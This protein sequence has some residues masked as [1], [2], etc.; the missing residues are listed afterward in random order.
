MPPKLCV[1]GVRV[2]AHQTNE[3]TTTYTSDRDR[4]A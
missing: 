1:G 2:F 4:L 3:L